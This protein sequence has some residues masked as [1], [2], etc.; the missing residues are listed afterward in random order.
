MT[1]LHLV[2]TMEWGGVRRHVLDL[3]DGLVVHGVRSLIASIV[4]ANSSAPPSLRSSRF[5]L[6]TTAYL[7]PIVSTASAT[8][9]GS[10]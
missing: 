6:V 10:S 9:R 8:R 3:A 7:R 1:V 5:T 4:N 2:N